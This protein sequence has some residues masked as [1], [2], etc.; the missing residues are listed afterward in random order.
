MN[1]YS[2]GKLLI[3]GEYLILKGA[4]SL[5]SPVNY[6]QFMQIHDFHSDQ[7][8]IW[9]SYENGICWFRAKIDPAFFKILETTDNQTANRLLAWLQAADQLNPGFLKRQMNKKVTVGSDFNLSWGLGSSSSLLSNIAWWANVDPFLLHKLVSNGS[10]YD[11]ICARENG[12][13][14][15]NLNSNSYHVEPADFDPVFKNRVFFIYSG[16]KQDTSKSLE[17][18]FSGNSSFTKEI[19]EVSVITRKIA[20]SETLAEFEECV[21]EHE[22]IMASVLRKKRIKEERFADLMGEIKSLGAWGGDFAM[23]TWHDTHEELKKYLSAKNID[24]IFSFN[25]MIKTR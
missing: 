16:R 21:R 10:G 2:S 12:P 14:H 20:I 11:V 9:E 23:I 24:T 3:T 19:E 17:T 6:G 4:V 5:A 18:F 7:C 15:F 13:V 25:E 22:E 8:L 1:Y